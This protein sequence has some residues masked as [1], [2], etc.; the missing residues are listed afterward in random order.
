MFIEMTV[1][2]AT[3]IIIIRA[4]IYWD[5][6]YFMCIELYILRMGYF[7]EFTNLLIN[8]ILDHLRNKEN[9]KKKKIKNLEILNILWYNIVVGLPG[10]QWEKFQTNY[11]K[12]K[13]HCIDSQKLEV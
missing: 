3:I 5:S 9:E 6:Q 13:G 12:C 10:W 11:L 7:S 4:N 1:N 2:I 8:K